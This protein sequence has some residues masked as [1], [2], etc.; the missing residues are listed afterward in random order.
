MADGTQ[1]LVQLT[2]VDAERAGAGL[3]Q[4]FANGLLF[5]CMLPDV[6]ARGR[7]FPGTSRLA[8]AAA[9]SLEEHGR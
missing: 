8:G 1:S 9:A 4:A 5:A 7:L 3:A 6:D 2:E